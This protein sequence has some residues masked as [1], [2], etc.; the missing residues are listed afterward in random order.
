MDDEMLKIY[1]YV[2]ISSYRRKTV[3]VLEY[4]D[5]TPTE[6]AKDSNIRINHISKVLKELKD[7]NVVVCINEQDRKGRIYH[8]TD[9][10]QDIA[11][12]LEDL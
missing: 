10:G 2:S 5:K 9:F 7:A 12:H 8:L 3:K 1:A 6:I 11:G 4:G